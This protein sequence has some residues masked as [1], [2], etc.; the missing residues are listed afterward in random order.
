MA[1]DV[2]DLPEPDSPT[3]PTIFPLGIENEMFFRISFLPNES[4]RFL[5]SSILEFK[6]EKI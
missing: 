4:E 1:N 6:S 5:M 3:I 2:M